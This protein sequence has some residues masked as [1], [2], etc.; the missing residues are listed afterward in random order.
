VEVGQRSGVQRYAQVQGDGSKVAPVGQLADSGDGIGD[1]GLDMRNVALCVGELHLL[2]GGIQTVEAGEDGERG[3]IVRGAGSDHGQLRV[4]LVCEKVPRG[5]PERPDDQFVVMFL[6][7]GL[8]VT[9]MHFIGGVE[10]DEFGGGGKGNADQVRVHVD[11]VAD[12]GEV[13]AR[14]VVEGDT[15]DA[16]V[17]EAIGHLDS[18]DGRH[19]QDADRLG[20]GSLEPVLVAE[21]VLARIPLVNAKR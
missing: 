15:D 1:G 14:A 20:V 12:E 4:G 7:P 9:V 10:P 13:A 6:A 18:V 11:E 5:P 8:R 19:F 17:L 21:G 16:L 2:A 3:L